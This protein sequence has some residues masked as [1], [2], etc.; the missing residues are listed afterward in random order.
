MEELDLRSLEQSVLIV[1]GDQDPFVGP[2]MADRLTDEIPGSRLVRLPGTGRL[3]PEEAPDT[4]TNLI[5][6]FAIAVAAR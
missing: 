5:L 1:W 2:R 6:D 4:L 3:V